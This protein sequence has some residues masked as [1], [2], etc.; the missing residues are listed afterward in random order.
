[1]SAPTTQAAP[2]ELR[3]SGTTFVNVLRSEWVKL[4][5]LR[6]TPWTLVAMLFVTLGITTLLCWATVANWDD[7][8]FDHSTFDPTSTSLSGLL[9]GQLA[10]GVLG[11]L[12]ITGEFTT[13][14]IRTTFTA[15]PHRIKVVMAKL[16]TFLVVALVAGL[17]TCFLS[18]WIGQ[19][20]F[21]SKD[22][23]AHLG[24][25]HVLRAVIGG[26]LY[27]AGCGAFGFALGTLLR[28]TA[29]AITALAALLFVLPLLSNIL[30]GKVGDTITNYFTSNAG[31][32]IT[33]TIPSDMLSP[34]KGYAVFTV[35][36]LLVLI[37]GLYLVE[38]V[39]P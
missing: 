20:F 38:R 26:G 22:A 15:V 30:P 28:K 21:A 23:E 18:F 34:W 3:A 6:S 39:D 31:A 12:V 11:A 19:L 9:F 13:G 4:W 35:E 32:R 16:L 36:W 24:D 2:R 37:V 29:I 27:V 33:D 5:S 7:P 1:M 10:I 25:P 14:G 8:S 17:V